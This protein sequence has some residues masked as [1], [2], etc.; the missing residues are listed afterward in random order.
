MLIKWVKI[1]L[2]VCLA[3]VTTG[4]MLRYMDVT[5]AAFSFGFN[6]A[7][8]FW[9]SVLETQLKPALDSPFFNSYPFEKEGRVYRMLGVEWYRAILIKSGWEKL[10]QKSTPIRKSLH[11][12]QAYER[13]SRVA[14]AGH[15]AAGVVVLIVTGYVMLAYSVRDALWLVVFNVLLNFYPVLLQ[16]YTRPRLLR[17][18]EK[19][20]KSLPAFAGRLS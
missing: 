6:F 4:L 2:V 19:L 7:Q 15:L 13:A 16:R 10:R 8:M 14:E 11:D 3:L 12:F 5:S 17:M 18:I 1:L 9:A 20:K